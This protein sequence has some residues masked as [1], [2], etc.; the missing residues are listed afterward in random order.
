MAVAELESPAMQELDV[1][2]MRA[3]REEK[4][5]TQTQAAAAADMKVSRWNDIESGGRRNVTVETLARIAGVLGCD[6][7]EL[8]TPASKKRGR[9]K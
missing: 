9:Q 4:G 5:L 2:R 7:R 6:A 1:A 8:L 3:L